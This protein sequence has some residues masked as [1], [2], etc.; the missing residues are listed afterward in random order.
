MAAGAKWL[1]LAINHVMETAP[2]PKLWTAG[3]VCASRLEADSEVMQTLVGRSARL[4]DQSM[5]SQRVAWPLFNIANC[6]SPRSRPFPP[7]TKFAAACICGHYVPLVS[8]AGR[9]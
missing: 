7:C 2:L 1:R 3:G 4:S 9:W 6:S 5:I 8:N